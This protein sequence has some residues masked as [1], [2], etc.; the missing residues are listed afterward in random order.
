MTTE[1]AADPELPPV[2]EYKTSFA[3]TRKEYTSFAY[4]PPKYLKEYMWPP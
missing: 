1:P 2:K 4:D 3:V